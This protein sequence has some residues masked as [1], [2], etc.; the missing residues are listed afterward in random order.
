[1][2]TLHEAGTYSSISSVANGG[3]EL[4][5]STLPA[6]ILPNPMSTDREATLTQS[7]SRLIETAKTLYAVPQV[8]YFASKKVADFERAILSAEKVLLSS[9]P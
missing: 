4:L 1:M 3:R 2:H 6:K 9:K 5:P 8:R 7:L